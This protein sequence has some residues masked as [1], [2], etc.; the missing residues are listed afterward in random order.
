[1]RFG[2]VWATRVVPATR[3]RLALVALAPGL[4]TVAVVPKCR[5]MVP[6]ALA[7]VPAALALVPAAGV[8]FS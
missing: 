5:G 7:P 8:S 3:R 1:M 4:G 6:V 2:V